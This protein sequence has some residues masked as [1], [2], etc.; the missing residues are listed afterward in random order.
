MKKTS[1]LIITLLASATTYAQVSQPLPVDIYNKIPGVKLIDSIQKSQLVGEIQRSYG[2]SGM[3]I[4]L[5]SNMHFTWYSFDCTSTTP[6]VKGSW[7]ILN[8]RILALEPNNMKRRLFDIVQFETYYFFVDPMDRK[9][10][11]FAIS[12][13]T[14]DHPSAYVVDGKKYMRDS[15]TH[16]GLNIDYFTIPIDPIMAKK[17][18][19]VRD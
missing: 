5:D 7:S 16:F 19:R 18:Q 13:L 12:K 8:N 17:F 9:E 4:R 15:V 6:L 14:T 1:I 10:F 3:T 11:V 2:L